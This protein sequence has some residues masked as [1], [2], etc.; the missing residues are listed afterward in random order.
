MDNPWDGIR[1]MAL[2]GRARKI[3]H[4]YKTM[5]AC[6]AAGLSIVAHF[7]IHALSGDDLIV[8]ILG[9]T[10]GSLLFYHLV[11]ARNWIKQEYGAYATKPG[12]IE[13]EESDILSKNYVKNG[14]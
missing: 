8:S 2:M 12:F 7:A 1:S 6:M 5:G 13:K 10:I 4:I 9:I 11:V 14:S 3:R